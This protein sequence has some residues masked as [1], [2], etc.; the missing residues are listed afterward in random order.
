MAYWKAATKQSNSAFYDPRRIEKLVAWGGFDSVKHITRYLQPGIDLITLD[1]KLSGTIIGKEAFA[2]DATLASVAKRLALDI[3]AQNQEAC[4]SAR[5]AYVQSGTDEAGLARCARLAGL[6]FEALQRL[7]DTLSTPH[8]AFDPVL[9]EELDGIRM[10]A[11]EYTVYGGR[12]NEGAVIVSRD[13]TP[14]SFS[15]I[16]GCRVG[17]L[18]PVDDISTAVRSVNA[19]TQTIGIFPETLKAALRDR[20]AW[21]GAQRL[22]SL[23]AAATLQHNLERQD[24]IEPLR[25]MVK[26][27]TEESAARALIESACGLNSPQAFPLIEGNHAYESD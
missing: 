21:Q 19:Y 9:K 7:P 22:V 8:K 3:G 24:A 6:T 16:L 23:G 27:V 5:V 18:V 4:V 14:V 20:L 12:G 15:R 10:F 1:P 26:W 13:G 17:N 2:D 25:R 11:D